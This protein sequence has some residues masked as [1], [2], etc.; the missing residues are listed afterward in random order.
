MYGEENGLPALT[1]RGIVTKRRYNLQVLWLPPQRWKKDCCLSAFNI[2]LFLKMGFW[3]IFLLFR[4]LFIF[5][6]ATDQGVP[7]VATDGS[8]QAIERGGS[9]RCAWSATV[10]K[11]SIRRQ[12]H[13]MHQHSLAPEAFAVFHALRAAH[14]VGRS[15][16]VLCNNLAVG[17][18]YMLGEKGALG[19]QPSS[20]CARFVEGHCSSWQCSSSIQCV[21]SHGKHRVG[22]SFTTFWSYVA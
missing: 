21:P 18:Y 7:I 12:L 19:R 9:K 11:P 13:G 22:T 16:L 20:L 1:S 4:K 8:A 6:S 5:Q 2:V 10:G 14:Q 15:I 17:C 3:C